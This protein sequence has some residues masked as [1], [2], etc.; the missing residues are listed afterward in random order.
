MKKRFV[1]GV[2]LILGLTAILALL[3]AHVPPALAADSE[4]LEVSTDQGE[5]TSD[6]SYYYK[7]QLVTLNLSQ[8]L[9]AIKERKALGIESMKNFNLARSPLS[10]QKALKRRGYILYHLQ[11]SQIEIRNQTDFRAKLSAIRTA[12]DGEVQ[13]VFE[14]GPALLIP[15]DEI[16]VGFKEETT[17]EQAWEF[18]RLI[19]IRMAFSR[20]VPIARTRSSCR[21]TT[22][23]M[24]A[25]IRFPESFRSWMKSVLQSP[26][27]SSFCARAQN[28][29]HRFKK[30]FS[31]NG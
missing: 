10:D 4:L 27:I 15:S 20:S 30:I 22:P 24:V 16:V 8:Q 21:S 12:I 25:S 31:E 14:Q 9:V 6:Y 17:L 28:C 1:L 23:Q 3:T 26:T 18:W 11:S 2:S 5:D 7:G 29:P 13:P 19:W